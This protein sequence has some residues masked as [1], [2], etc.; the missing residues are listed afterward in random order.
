MRP[1]FLLCFA[2]SLAGVP[3][4]RRLRARCPGRSA[5]NSCCP[6]TASTPARISTG[7]TA[8]TS[9]TLEKIDDF[10]HLVGKPQAIVASSSYWGEQTFPDANVRLIARHGSVPLL[11]W[12]PWDRPY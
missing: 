4:I 3:A 10:E 11:Y 5:G 12:S 6:G 9:V 8:R 2:L 1:L 7:A